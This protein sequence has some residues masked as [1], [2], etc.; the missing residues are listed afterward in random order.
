MFAYRYSGSNA[1]CCSNCDIG[2]GGDAGS[3]Y[4][5]AGHTDYCSGECCGVETGGA[6]GEKNIDQV[7]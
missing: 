1:G 5:S 7:W 3:G 6:Y 2:C 4:G